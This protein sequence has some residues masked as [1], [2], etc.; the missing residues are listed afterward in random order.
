MNVTETSFNCD[1]N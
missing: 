1:R